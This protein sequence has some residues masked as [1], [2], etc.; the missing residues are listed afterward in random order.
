MG[1]S[2]KY[3]VIVIGATG[4]VGREVLNILHERSFP[5]DKIEVV[6]S[7][8][9]LGKKVS[10]G[11]KELAVVA[12]DN[13][14]FSN[15]DIVFS[16]AGSELSKTFVDKANKAGAI[17]IDKTS[18][19]RMTHDVP[20]IV[21]EVNI[22]ELRKGITRRIIS[23]PNCIVIPIVMALKVLDNF[24][25]IKRVVLST[26]QSTSG[27]GKEG[28]DELH[29]QTKAKYL[30][31]NIGNKFFSHQIAFNL[32]PQ[33]GDINEDG[34]SSEEEK[35]SQEISKIMDR[36]IPTSATC[37]RVPVF[38]GHSISLN[39]EFVSSIDVQA[40]EN[41]LSE[42]DGISVNNIVTPVDAVGEDDIFISRIRKD[43]SQKN[44]INMWI[45][46]DNLRKGAALN[47]IQIAEELI[48][49]I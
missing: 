34:I 11:D 37:V 47:S 41:I 3:N 42:T 19:F 23:T 21:P 7:R 26:Y 28:M 9:S 18:C 40:V 5:V 46:S 14:D 1:K 35:I 10:F 4:N 45:V 32:I 15:F 44:T 24:V 33:I 36:D 38:V 39:I 12:I 13:V 43:S 20:L 30:Y 31:Q 22:Q 27:A 6:A 8:S 49:N 17:V 16:C 29:D 48:K 2:K 25:K